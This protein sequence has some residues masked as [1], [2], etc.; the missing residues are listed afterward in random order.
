MNGRAILHLW[1]KLLVMRMLRRESRSRQLIILSWFARFIRFIR[2]KWN[3]NRIIIRKAE[4]DHALLKHSVW[5]WDHKAGVQHRGVYKPLVVPKWVFPQLK[6]SK[7][8]QLGG[9][10]PAVS[11]WSLNKSNQ[12]DLLEEACHRIVE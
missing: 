7:S 5:V 10:I 12:S 8:M 1:K 9:K 11:A 4:V 6:M 2:S 3:D